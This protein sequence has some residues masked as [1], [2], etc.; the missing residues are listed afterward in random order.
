MRLRPLFLPADAAGSQ[1]PIDGERSDV[2]SVSGTGAPH[3][4]SVLPSLDAS[5]PAPPRLPAGLL[6]RFWLLI[7]CLFVAI[8]LRRCTDSGGGASPGTGPATPAVNAT[9]APGLPTTVNALPSMNVDQ[10][11]A[12][13]G[14]LSG[15]PLVVNVWAA[16]CAPCKQE[17]PRLVAAA[18]AQ[19][20]R[21]VPRGGRP[22]F[23]RSGAANFLTTYGGHVPER[24]RSSGARSRPT[25]GRSASRTRTSTMQPAGRLRRW[26]GPSPRLRWMPAWR[27]SAPRPDRLNPSGSLGEPWRRPVTS[28]ARDPGSARR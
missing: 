4:P 1:T 2:S 23:D 15:T 27:R 17:A 25:W 18:K 28:A 6:P 26:P 14:E 24:L 13:L 7:G 12:L 22:G 20:R 11:N 16:W 9:P 21:P 19:P 10:F 3:P 5:P 8:I